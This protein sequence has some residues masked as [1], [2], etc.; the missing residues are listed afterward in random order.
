MKIPV[1]QEIASI[2]N[3]L[4]LAKFSVGIDEHED[5]MAD[6]EKHLSND[7]FTIHV[8]VGVSD[9]SSIHIMAADENGYEYL[10]EI[11]ANLLRLV[12]IAVYGREECKRKHLFEWAYSELKEPYETEWSVD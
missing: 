5:R 6:M 8:N 7:D 10:I 2:C 4:R 3:S 12:D 11:R 1:Y 9:D